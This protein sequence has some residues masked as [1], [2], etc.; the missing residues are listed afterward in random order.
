[1]STSRK[2]SPLEQ[3]IHQAA[4]TSGERTLTSKALATLVPDVNERKIALNFLLG[5]GLLKPLE[6]AG[7]KLSFRGVVKGELEMKKDLSA[8][9]NLVLNLIAAAGNEGIWT[10]HLKDKSELHQAIID[11]CLKLLTQKQLVKVLKGSVQQRNRRI[12][13][14]FHLEPSAEMTGGP[15]YTDKEL[16][17]EFIKL[18]SQACLKF[19]ADRV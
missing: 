2:L 14:L 15:W 12:Y 9:E 18:L 6:N 7:G 13:M 10:K 5:A 19:I 8:E 11:K 4:L 1:M 16:D 17:T 3:K